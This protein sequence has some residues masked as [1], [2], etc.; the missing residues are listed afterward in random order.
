MSL[1]PFVLVLFTPDIQS[2]TCG[3]LIEADSNPDPN[4]M[5]LFQQSNRYR[6][7]YL[8]DEEIEAAK[9][10]V[11]L[12]AR[13]LGAK[14][15]AYVV[16]ACFA[17]MF[18]SCS[19]TC[20]DRF[21]VNEGLHLRLQWAGL[22][23]FA[24]ELLRGLHPSDDARKSKSSLN[25]LSSLASSVLPVVVSEPLWTLP[26]TLGNRVSS[27]SYSQAQQ[28]R[29]NSNNDTT[30][31]VTIMNSNAIMVSAL[32]GLICQFTHE[33]ALGDSM[34]LHLPTILFPL[35]ERASPIGNHSSVQ[36]AAFSSLWDVSLA[37]GYSDISSLLASNFDYLVDAISLRLKKYA[38]EQSP[39]ERSL[40]GVVDVI[41]QSLVHHGRSDSSLEQ[42]GVALA[43]GHV[44]MIGHLL[45]C[46]LS[47]FDR[48]SYM[49]NLSL[50]D[51]VG[52]FR[53]MGIFMETSIDFY[54]YNHRTEV[55]VKSPETG[56]D[57][58]F[59]RLD[60]ELD[61]GSGGYHDD[62][63]KDDMFSE[64]EPTDEGEP[65]NEADLQQSSDDQGDTDFVH[66][67][68]A[69]NSILSRCSYLLCYADLQIQVLCCETMQSGLRSLGKIG[70]FRKNLR[71]EAA[72][73]PLLPSI[74]EFWPSIIARLRS[75]STSLASV[76]K[77][78]RSDLAIRHAMAKDQEQGPSR[79]GLEVLM[80]KLLLVI[81][82]LCLGSDG[83]FED[84]FTNDVYPII[85]R[86][87]KDILSR[88]GRLTH[89]P[90]SLVGEKH[91]LL[92]PI[93][94]FF[95]TSYGSSCGDGLVGLIP[96]TG[97]MIFPLLSFEGPIGSAAVDAVKAMLAV[98]CDALWRS[99][100][101][102]SGRSFPC[103]PVV[104]TAPKKYKGRATT[105]TM[106]LSSQHNME[107]VLSQ[108]AVHLLEFIQCLPEQP[109][110]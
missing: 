104:D 82:E 19:R 83:F 102:L 47:H 106:I 7:L 68:A 60:F 16:D 11:R 53:S 51:T 75:T 103:H 52:V 8:K 36:R 93:L 21:L 90:T 17:E 108:R 29:D 79:A 91:S 5:V 23:V 71:G 39:M 94:Q 66:E 30:R 70:A 85:A 105:A 64:I 87:V 65:L 10:T 101:N 25:I 62:E 32:M 37:I 89:K 58:W 92:L 28:M 69:I 61:I 81:S 98:D 3:P 55:E 80:S 57:E 56:V 40:L 63:L 59:Q 74:G 4:K 67:I 100:Q 110:V 48:Q 99:L 77:L 72:S 34:M 46:L 13:T 86:L 88:D 14:R 1:L 12:F 18:E 49:T 9:N 73:N 43:A 26:T 42:S 27:S 50:F 20:N 2:I 44:A 45:K 84:R 22:C 54:I 107:N 96:S 33:H 31:S 38:R 109:V 95:K 76:N 24:T 41:L 78:S 15:C 6:F 97:T 35:L